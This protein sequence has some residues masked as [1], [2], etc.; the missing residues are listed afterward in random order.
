MPKTYDDHFMTQPLSYIKLMKEIQFKK[1]MTLAA[2][3]KFADEELQ[4]VC[5][6]HS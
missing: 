6:V 5:E 4:F 2:A 3:R 1:G